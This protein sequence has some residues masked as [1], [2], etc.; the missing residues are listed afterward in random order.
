MPKK[1]ATHIQNTAPGPPVT[2]A[3][4]TPA[5]L[6]VPTVAASA[7]HRAWNW[8]IFFLSL[9]LVVALSL[10]EGPYLAGVMGFFSGLLLAVHSVTVEGLGCLYLS[11]VGVVL[12]WLFD[13]YFRRNILLPI[14]AGTACIVF[15]EVCKYV[16]Y[17]RLVHQLSVG[18]GMLTL[19]GSFILSVPFGV[20]VCFVVRWLFHMFE[21]EEQ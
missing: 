6:P 5:M 21:E 12:G 3:A 7:A 9:F 18:M 1:A 13:K 15:A 10:Y 17:Y 16:F 2:M 8:E 20:L 19:A 11:V 14:M 4:A